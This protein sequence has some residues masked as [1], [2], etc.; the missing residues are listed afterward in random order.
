[1]LLRNTLASASSGILA[2]IL[3]LATFPFLLKQVGSDDYGIFALASAAVGY[4]SIINLAARASVV[5]YTAEYSERDKESL[6]IFFTNALILNSLL[7]IIISSFLVMLA[8][9]CDSFFSLS[10]ANIP[11]ARQIILLNAGATLFFQPLSVFGSLLYGFQKHGLVAILDIIW[12]FTRNSVILVIYLCNGTILWLVWHEIIMQF[13]KYLILLFIVMK[14]YTF[15][16]IN[17]KYLNFL[18]INK[19]FTYGGLSLLYTLALLM[20]YQGSM[21]LTGIFISVGSITYLQIAY[22]VFNII[23]SLALYLSSAVLPSSSAAIAAG[24]NQYIDNLISFGLKIILSIGLPIIVILFI[25]IPEILSIW[26]GKEFA[27][28]SDIISRMLIFSWLFYFPTTFL[29]QIYFG[30]KDIAIFSINSFLSSLVTTA[31]SILLG[32]LYAIKGIA[33][34]CSI[35]YVYLGVTGF[36]LF[37]NKF[38]L[39]CS[40][41]FKNIITPSYGLNIILA[42]IMFI[43]Y[44]YFS[45]SKNILHFLLELIL[46][47]FIFIG[48]NI[49][50]NAKKEIKIIFKIY[51]KVKV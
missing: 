40:I 9:W 26:I 30:Q 22:K 36:F 25:F 33:L 18:T 27:D 15:L 37:C 19:I 16:S 42:I 13:L 31:T 21:I 34:A 11:R 44:Y 46:I 39:S 10:E 3:A 35:F 29:T 20:V 24:D 49:F 14:K 23:N 51:S 6:N 1:M 5:K 50:F 43:I 47:T 41:I 48:L 32:S 28:Q 17:I 45:F 38:K 4:F 2:Q 8:V 12:T 7:G